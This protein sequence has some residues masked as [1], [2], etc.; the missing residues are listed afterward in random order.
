MDNV[1]SNRTVITSTWYVLGT[2]SNV[3]SDELEGELVVEQRKNTT[4]KSKPIPLNDI[5]NEFLIL[6]RKEIAPGIYCN[7]AQAGIT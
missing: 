1:A 7:N 2:R 6:S 4:G 5:A 3:L